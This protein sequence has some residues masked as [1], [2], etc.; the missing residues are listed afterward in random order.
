MSRNPRLSARG[1]PPITQE[2]LEARIRLIP[3]DTRDSTGRLLGD[4]IPNDPRR[5]HY[6]IEPSRK[7]NWSF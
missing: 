4:P 3:E 2:E 7:E 6:K 5:K 1:R